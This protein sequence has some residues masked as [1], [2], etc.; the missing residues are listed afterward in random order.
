MQTLQA[1][2]MGLPALSNLELN[3]FSATPLHM[4][5]SHQL[6]VVLEIWPPEA[7]FVLPAK[8]EY[9]SQHLG[10]ARPP[11]GSACGLLVPTIR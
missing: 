1:H 5:D 7:A 10:T 6:S 3:L 4:G 9:P 8:H 11:A 2:N